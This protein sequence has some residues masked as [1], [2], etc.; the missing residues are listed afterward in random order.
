M[1]D[2]L[3]DKVAIVTG[4][5]RGIGRGVAM[6]M[7]EEGAQVVF[8]GSVHGVVVHIKTLSGPLLSPFAS[9][10]H[11]DKNSLSSTTRKRTSTVGDVLSIY[12]TSASANAD[13]QS[14]HQ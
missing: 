10:E 3:K 4:S 8:A 9:A 12:S 6:L 5:G 2:I 1:T 7:A 13:P 11:F 14:A